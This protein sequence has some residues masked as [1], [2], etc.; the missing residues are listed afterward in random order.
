MAK[1]RTYY[2][3]QQASF[4]N[5]TAIDFTVP[6]DDS[7]DYHPSRSLTSTPGGA[8]ATGIDTVTPGINSGMAAKRLNADLEN[9]KAT[10]D[11]IYANVSKTKSDTE[12]NRKLMTQSDA[13][14][15]LLLNS[16]KSAMADWKLKAYQLPAAKFN[17]DFNSTESGKK[18][19]LIDRIIKSL[20]G[21]LDASN[22]AKS[23]IK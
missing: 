17:A 5:A 8:A 14:T 12:L 9:L 15:N 1:F 21:G 10:N 7:A 6:D 22:S 23:L 19:M 2:D 20:T 3:D 13:Q 16:A 11:Q 4:S 18:Q